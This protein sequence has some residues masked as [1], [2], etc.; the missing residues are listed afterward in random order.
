MRR[1]AP[2]TRRDAPLSPDGGVVADYHGPFGDPATLAAW[3]SGTPGVVE[4]GLFPSEM[5]TTVL[6]GRGQ[7][8]DV[9]YPP[10]RP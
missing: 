3:L 5:V 2:V 4:H 9:T 6:V 10:S 8:V 1:I 7:S